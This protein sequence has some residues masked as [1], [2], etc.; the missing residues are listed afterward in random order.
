MTEYTLVDSVFE[1][2]NEHSGLRIGIEVPLLGRSVDL[3]LMLEGV[4]ITV[5]FKLR[6]WRKA[7][8][9]ANDHLLG[10]DYSYICVPSSSITPALMDSVREAGIGLFTVSKSEDWP[11]EVLVEAPPSTQTWPAARENVIQHLCDSSGSKTAPY[12]VAHA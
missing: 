12:G 5:E 8:V 2:L 10:A 9:Q 7:L 11:L 1:K 3:V 4:V 6:D